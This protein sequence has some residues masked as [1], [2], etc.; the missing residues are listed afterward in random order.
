[1]KKL[2][3]FAAVLTLLSTL[4]FGGIENRPLTVDDATTINHGEL[5]ANYGLG[6]LRT[7]QSIINTVD[8]SYGIYKGLEFGIELPYAFMSVNS[9][10]TYGLGD[11]MLRPEYTFYKETEENWAPTLALATEVR[12]PWGQADG[13]SGAGYDISIDALVTKKVYKEF[14]LYLNLAYVI[15][16]DT[17]D[18]LD[19]GLAGRYPVS[20]KF[21]LVTEI[22]NAH[23]VKTGGNGAIS[24]LVGS[25]WEVT[26]N[27][28]IDLGVGTNFKEFADDLYALAGVSYLF[29]L[30]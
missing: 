30:F 2:L 9:N 19:Y 11:L 21:W 4:A 14:A 20:D 27:L 6:Y 17:P 28:T 7:T 10:R 13:G 26:K 29:P 24:F 25:A 18:Y 15:A 8:L 5:H 12:T 23:F 22:T 3:S 16:T 1:M